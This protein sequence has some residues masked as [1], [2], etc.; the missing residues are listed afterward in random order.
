MEAEVDEKARLRPGFCFFSISPFYRR[1]Q[2][3][4]WKKRRG[5][6]SCEWSPLLSDSSKT[7]FGGLVTDSLLL[8]NFPGPASDARAPQSFL[9]VTLRLHELSRF[10]CGQP[11]AW[12]LSGRAVAGLPSNLRSL[13]PTWKIA[14]PLNETVLLIRRKSSRRE[15]FIFVEIL[16]VLW[17]LGLNE[18]WE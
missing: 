2:A 6:R 18:D 17:I 16:G 1:G 7:W 15:A 5:E 9:T 4:L 11:V 3:F 12:V 13:S 10:C 14:L 8:L